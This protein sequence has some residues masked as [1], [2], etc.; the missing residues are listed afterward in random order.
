MTARTPLADK[1]VVVTR[2]VAQ[3][4]NLLSSLGQ[5]PVK[6][7]Q[8]PTIEIRAVENA[9]PATDLFRSLA[10][11]D[12][13]I[14]N[15][16][17][18]VHHAMRL[19]QSLS[20]TFGKQRIAA[21]GPA[22]RA[23]LEQYGLLT[24]VVPKTGFRSED[25]LDHE[26]LQGQ[27]ILIVRGV[28]GREYLVQRLRERGARVDIAEVYLRLSPAT[29]PTVDLCTYSVKNSVV[30]IHSA[31]SAHNLWALCTRDEQRWIATVALIAGSQRI[32]DTATAI[33]FVKSPIIAK[34]ASD[35]AMLDALLTWAQTSG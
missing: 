6:I 29:R 11:Y 17:N 14:F 7:I 12:T 2:P 23:A 34:D 24:D 1:T 9:E 4:Q 5:Y 18:A 20:T 8:F 13:V 30:L 35:A 25:L 21:L 32:A 27:N 33:G 3:A 15:S 16:V 19:I 22:T 28:G 10:E 26:G 31:D